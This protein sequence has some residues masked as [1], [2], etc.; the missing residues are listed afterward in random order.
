MD[1]Y[2]VTGASRGIGKALADALAADPRAEVLTL[3][4]TPDAQTGRLRNYEID[5]TASDAV[6]GV[7]QR[8]LSECTEAHYDRAVLINNAGVLAPVA[9]LVECELAQMQ[10]S[11]AVNV[12]APLVLMQH[13]IAATQRLAAA[14]RIINIS[15]GAGKRP[16]AG[17]A[18]YCAA[19]AALDMASRV[20]ALEAERAGPGLRVCSLAPGVVD[21]GMQAQ[22]RGASELEFPDVARFRAMKEEGALRAPAEVAAQIVAL[23]HADAFENGAT[24]D[25]RE[26]A[27]A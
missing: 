22:L 24:H 8:A 20:A 25:L 7:L 26:M 2:I 11:L 23:I 5:L 13:F 17:W 3:S 27:P 15:S 4:R 10:A 21:T 16:I 19:K 6:A 18:L 1:L 12:L 9:P 14:R